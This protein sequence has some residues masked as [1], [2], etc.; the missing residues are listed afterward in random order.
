MRRDRELLTTVGVD[1]GGELPHGTS[2]DRHNSASL[3]RRNVPLHFCRARVRSNRLMESR[4]C[5]AR[6]DAK[7]EVD[8]RLM[9]G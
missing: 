4:A 1:G 8:L 7:L 5:T 6:N 3:C 2:R 9:N